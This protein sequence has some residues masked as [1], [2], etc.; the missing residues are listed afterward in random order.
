MEL[1]NPD[2]GRVPTSVRK[3]FTYDLRIKLQEVFD[4][5]L[6]ESTQE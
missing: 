4:N 1:K 5:A 2:G 6:D 3:Q